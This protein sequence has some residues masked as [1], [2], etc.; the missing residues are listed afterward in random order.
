M[1]E[2]PLISK[3]PRYVKKY[4][5]F[6][7]DLAQQEFAFQKYT[8]SVLAAAVVVASRRALRVM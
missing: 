7:C 6:F 5:D 2:R 8:P 1:A 4:M 3:V